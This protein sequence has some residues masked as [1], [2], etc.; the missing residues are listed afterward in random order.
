MVR[1][2]KCRKIRFQPAADYFKPRGIPMVG[3]GVVEITHEEMEALKLKNVN[4]LDQVEAAKKM[5]TSQ[6]TFQR[7]LVSAYRKVSDALVN[8]KAIKVIKDE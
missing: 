4:D 2:K 1:P 5:K 8:G 7:I 3:L 6:S